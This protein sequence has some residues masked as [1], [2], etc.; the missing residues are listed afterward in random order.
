MYLVHSC[1]SEQRV[2]AELKIDS[3]DVNGQV[4]IQLSIPADYAMD[5][6]VKPQHNATSVAGTSR[7]LDTPP[8]LY[9][10]PQ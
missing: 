3:N 5:V 6:Y 8:S 2:A 1:C 9:R 10:L 7:L 4:T